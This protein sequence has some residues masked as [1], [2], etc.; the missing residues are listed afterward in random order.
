MSTVETKERID[1]LGEAW[2][3]FKAVNDRRLAELE[4][5]HKLRI[6]CPHCGKKIEST[7]QE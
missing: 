4:T 1:A 3:R 5:K 2:E 7:K 6:N